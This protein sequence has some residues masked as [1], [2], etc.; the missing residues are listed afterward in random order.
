MTTNLPIA[1]TLSTDELPARLHEIRSLS[2]LALRDKRLDGV[3]A[4]LRFAPL[5]GVHERLAAIV[6][7][8]SRCCA[9]LD[10][11]LA[12][13]PTELTLTI[14]APTDAAPVLGMLLDAFD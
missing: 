7:A 4:E 13:T 9:F 12:A 2:R 10:I 3:R 14:E 5:R 1:C 8:E 11:Q 6:A